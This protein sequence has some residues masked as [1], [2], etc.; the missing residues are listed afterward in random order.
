MWAT[1]NEV[2][3]PG[4]LWL[5]LLSAAPS[6]GLVPIVLDGLS[7]QPERPWDSGELDPQPAPAL[8]D[9]DEA[10]VFKQGWNKGV[11]LGLLPPSERP[12]RLG[13]PGM[14]SRPEPE[15]EEDDEEREFFLELVAP[16]GITFP[17]LALEERQSGD[18]QTYRQMVIGTASGRLGLVETNRSADILHAIGW[19][20]AAN[21]FISET[22]ATPLSMMMR[23]WEDRF[24]ARLFRL[25]F[26]TLVFAVERPAST[27]SSALAIAAEH[28]AFAGD[29]GFHTYAD[30]PVD[31]MRT[32]AA[33]LLGNPTWRFW[34]D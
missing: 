25:G 11:P 18:Q 34:F 22:G 4:R 3:D 7:R 32:L 10:V 8:D 2:A 27:G 31:S 5:D 29:D 13:R 1:M 14:E 33:V 19:M 30:S 12:P 9:L 17:G 16:W 15:Y 23:S 21:H 24:G 6:T 28:F 26:D 20:G